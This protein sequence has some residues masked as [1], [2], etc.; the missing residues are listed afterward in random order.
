MKLVDSDRLLEHKHSQACIPPQ[1][2]V[3]V[4]VSRAAQD[5]NRGIICVR[6]CGMGVCVED[7]VMFV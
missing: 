5:V 3:L 7:S 2:P 1:L 4:D 6:V